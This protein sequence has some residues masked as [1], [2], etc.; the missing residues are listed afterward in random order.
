M[1]KK[2]TQ[3]IEIGNLSGLKVSKC[4]DVINNIWVLLKCVTVLMWQEVNNFMALCVCVQLGVSYSLALQN[5]TVLTLST[6]ADIMKY[7]VFCGERNGDL[8]TCLKKVQ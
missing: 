1:W 3:N 7:M 6:R 4:H 5:K 8:A 2:Q